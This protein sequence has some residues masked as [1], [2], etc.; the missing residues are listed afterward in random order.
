MKIPFTDYPVKGVHIKNRV[1][2]KNLSLLYV[3]MLIRRL[4]VLLLY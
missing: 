2:N 3:I 1:Y 4:Q